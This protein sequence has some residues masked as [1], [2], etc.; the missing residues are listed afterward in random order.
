MMIPRPLVVLSLVLSSACSAEAV[1]GVVAS[2]PSA[3]QNFKVFSVEAK[4]S[5]PVKALPQGLAVATSLLLAFNSG[6]SNGACLGGG[7]TQGAR[8]QAVS[9]VTGAWTTSAVGFASGDMAT[10][11]TNT[12]CMGSYLGGSLIAGFLNPKPVPFQLGEKVGLSFLIG[13]ALMFTASQMAGKDPTALT[14]FLLALVANGLSNSVTSV[15]TAN[16]CRTAHFSGITSDMGTFIGQI[17]GG[18]NANLFKL[19]VFAGLAA[20]FWIG[21][22]VAFQVA[23]SMASS[24][25]MVCAI[26][27]AL[28]ALSTMLL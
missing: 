4:A 6:F 15:H 14:P 17:L 10:F 24:S 8:K 7:L 2:L 9:A 20:C 23:Q 16:L 21:G 3:N 27:Y 18:N 25:L 19:K 12:K 13:S 1:K 11:K 26:L 22:A 28:T 5:K